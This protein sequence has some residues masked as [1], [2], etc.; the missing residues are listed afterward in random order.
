MGMF[1]SIFH[2]INKIRN[3]GVSDN[4][5]PEDLKYIHLINMYG[6]VI[7]LLMLFLILFS[8][9]GYYIFHMPSSIIKVQLIIGTVSLPMFLFTFVL[10]SKKRFTTARNYVF[11]VT[12]VGIIVSTFYCGTAF[13]SPLLLLTLA[14]SAAVM[15]PKNERRWM[16]GIVILCMAVFFIIGGGYD[17]GYLK[18]YYP[19]E[20]ILAP[21]DIFNAKGVTFLFVWTG[22]IFLTVFAHNAAIRA[23]EIL[24]DER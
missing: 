4:I 5:T 11:V 22:A 3:I 24:Q 14:I 17:L 8:I 1:N 9:S 7:S 10:T 16:V 23:E 15:F 20:T 12:L 18:A 19:I 13:Q 6:F 21:I 2:L